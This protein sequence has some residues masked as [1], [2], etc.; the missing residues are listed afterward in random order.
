MSL[1]AIILAG[2]SGTRLWPIS[3]ADVPKHLLPL[4]PGGVT[5]LRATIDRLLPMGATVHIVTVASQAAACQAEATAAGLGPDSV[6]AEPMP[7]GTGPA[8]GLA[9]RWIARQDPDALICSVH[10]DAHIGDDDGYRASI[11]AAAGWACATDGLVTVGLTPTYA[12]TGLGYIALGRIH[13]PED[14]TEPSGAAAEHEALSAAASGLAAF[15]A[16]GFVEKPPLPVAER[17]VADHSHLWNLGLFAWRAGAFV[18]ELGE[19]APE[20]DRALVGVVEARAAGAEEEV[21]RRYA[22]IANVAVDPLVLE[23]TSHLTVVQAGF[24]WS[25]L[26]SWSDLMEA[27]HE[28]G[29]V[30][31]DGNV[32]GGDA[33]ALDSSGCLV[34]ARGGR[35]VAVVGATGLV[36][37]DTGDAVLV[38]P[39]DRVQAVRAVVERLRSQGRT[40]LV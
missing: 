12:S 7:R 8:L 30:D 29:E 24:P 23:K 27:R 31:A 36:V 39:V 13:S 15:T 3:R 4:G 2:G 32:V 9:V 14:W 10:A 35:L 34:D 20:V 11:W 37:V 5:L 33:L 25:D 6:I 18:R 26:G 16:A 40:D 22:D 17:Y 21:A 19:A 1:H 28:M 38:V